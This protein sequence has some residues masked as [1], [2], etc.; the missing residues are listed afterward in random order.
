MSHSYIAK[1]TTGFS[2]YFRLSSNTLVSKHISFNMSCNDDLDLPCYKSISFKD[3][4]YFNTCWVET[5]GEEY[6]E[7]ENLGM[8]SLYSKATLAAAGTITGIESFA[9]VIL[10]AIILIILIRSSELRNEYLTP[11]IISIA[12]TDFLFCL[13]SLPI[14]SLH[15]FM[16]DWILSSCTFITFLNLALWYCS[17]MNL[18]GIAVL[19][20]IGVYFPGKTKTKTFVNASR[21]T[22]CL[23]WVISFVSLIPSLNPRYGRYGIECQT[24]ICAFINIDA[25]GKSIKTGALDPIRMLIVIMVLLMLVLN[26]AAYIKV[27][28]QSQNMYAQMKDT[29]TEIAERI[30]EKEK[31]V[32]QMMAIVTL[33]FIIVYLPGVILRLMYRDGHVTKPLTTL[34]FWLISW[35][36]GI[37]DPVLYII[38][39]ERYQNEIKHLLQILKLKRPCGNRKQ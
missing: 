10:N 29:S 33:L 28:R 3:S 39:Q 8:S 19:R 31:K 9:G 34:L 14:L 18:L 23:A 24:L 21:V 26:V 20:C 2:I 4:A 7:T 12:L 1:T 5:S 35:L 22:P 36:I 30:L 16:E 15:F 6:A 32:G 13:I 27:S 38:F 37:I 11:S 17:A 25:D